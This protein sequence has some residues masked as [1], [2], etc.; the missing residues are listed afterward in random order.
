MPKKTTAPA[1]QSGKN[2]QSLIKKVWNMADV[3]SSAGVGFTD[4]I[5]QL[6][7][8]L[9]LK[10]DSEKVEMIG[11]ESALPKGCEWKDLLAVQMKGA[12]LVEKYDSILERLSKQQ[13]LIGTI[14]V[15]AQNMSFMQS[16]IFS[17]LIKSRASK[18]SELFRPNLLWYPPDSSHLPHGSGC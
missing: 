6:T 16:S 15:D 17:S 1:T 4:Y 5:T 12:E 13:G 7:Y 10:M 14:F 3:L 18:S 2:E 11:V 9:F 8:L